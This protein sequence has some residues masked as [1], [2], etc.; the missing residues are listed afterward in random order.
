ML[1]SSMFVLIVASWVCVWRCGGERCGGERSEKK[2]VVKSTMK[3]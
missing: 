2:N 3:F 1:A